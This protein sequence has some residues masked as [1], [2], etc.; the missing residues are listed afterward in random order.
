MNLTAATITVWF[1]GLINFHGGGG[2][3]DVIVPLTPAGKVYRGET[4]EP[5]SCNVV[6]RK[7][8]AGKSGCDALEGVWKAPPAPAEPTCTVFDVSQKTITLPSSSARFITSPGNFDLVPKLTDLC[9]GLADLPDADVHDATKHAAIVTITNGKLDACMNGHAWVSNLI[10]TGTTGDLV[11]GDKAASL[12]HDAVVVIRNA[13][14]S[15]GGTHKQHFWW[16]YALYND[17]GTCGGKIRDG[18][19]GEEESPHGCPAEV[20]AFLRD[21]DTASGVGCSNTGYP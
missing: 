11:I 3:R 10:L 6:I 12:D 2:G 21:I 4:L 20:I 19:P 15:S 8:T 5:H 9:S 16:Y 13:P 1:V 17:T 14:I 7:L 18:L